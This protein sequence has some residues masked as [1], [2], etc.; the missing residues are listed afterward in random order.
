MTN[1]DDQLCTLYKF[2]NA[3]VAR[4]CSMETY[5]T[6]TDSGQFW[7][8]WGEEWAKRNPGAGALIEVSMVE[9]E[10]EP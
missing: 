4:V 9:L 2:Q 7:W 6:E 1:A 5:N 3:T 10:V 8:V